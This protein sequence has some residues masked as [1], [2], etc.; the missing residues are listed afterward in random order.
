VEIILRALSAE[1]VF[2]VMLSALVADVIGRQFDGSAPFLS[3]F[4]SGIALHH[5]SSYLLVAVLAVIA[6]LIG[7]AFKNILYATEDLCD[8]LWNDRPELRCRRLS[9][10][11]AGCGGLHRTAD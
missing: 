11:A 10:R 7:L 5:L 8:R 1:A 3:G 2:T 4:P 6:A 9:G